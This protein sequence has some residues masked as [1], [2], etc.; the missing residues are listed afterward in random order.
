MR[1]WPRWKPTICAAMVTRGPQAATLR[2]DGRELINFASN[3]YLGLASDPRLV[4]AATQAA[5]EAG[6]GAAPAR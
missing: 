5:A 6:W 2:V 4:Q 1:S 3:D